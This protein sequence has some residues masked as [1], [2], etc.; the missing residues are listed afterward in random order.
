M[1]TEGS[2]SFLGEKLELHFRGRITRYLC[3]FVYFLFM[4]IFSLGLTA[5]IFVFKKS[6][7][8][9]GNFVCCSNSPVKC[10]DM[11]RKHKFC[12]ITKKAGLA[13]AICHS[14][15]RVLHYPPYQSAVC[16]MNLFLMRSVIE[17]TSSLYFLTWVLILKTQE[18]ILKPWDLI[19]ESFEIQELSCGNQGAS[20]C[21]L[22]CTF[23][24]YRMLL[25][26]PACFISLSLKELDILHTLFIIKILGHITHHF[27]QLN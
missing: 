19:L 8:W 18:L 10:V 9:A 17:V 24:W 13:K 5:K 15:Q 21:Q 22:T 14:P 2:R 3:L 25:I 26:Y 12:F 1:I 27:G 16:F 23:E 20:D 7:E 11:F 4:V 6:A